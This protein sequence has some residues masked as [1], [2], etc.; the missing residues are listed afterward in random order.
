MEGEHRRPLLHCW[1]EMPTWILVCFMF[2]LRVHLAFLWVSVKQST[3][4]PAPPYRPFCHQCPFPACWADH[5]CSLLT[6]VT[7]CA[8]QTNLGDVVFKAPNSLPLL[9]PSHGR[10]VWQLGP[11]PLLGHAVCC[12]TTVYL[13]PLFPWRILLPVPAPPRTC[14][15]GHLPSLLLLWSE[16]L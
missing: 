6:G 14:M 12:N 1:I 7:A 9:S 3:S 13:P 4:P 11:L 5:C 8:L 15:L 2:P 10:Y 16:F